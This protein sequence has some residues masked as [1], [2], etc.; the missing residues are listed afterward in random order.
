MLLAHHGLERANVQ[1]SKI[2]SGDIIGLDEI[3]DCTSD[4]INKLITNLKATTFTTSIKI[5]V[6]QGNLVD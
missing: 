6:V 1:K 3:I 4:D 2:L 5:D